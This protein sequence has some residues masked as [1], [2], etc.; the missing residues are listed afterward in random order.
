M[1][2]QPTE[3][4]VVSVFGRTCVAFARNFIRLS[5]VTGT[6][7]LPSFSFFPG[8]Q[9]PFLDLHLPVLAI[10]QLL[11]STMLLGQAIVVQYVFD[12]LAGEPVSLVA[13]TATCLRRFF[14]IAGLSLGVGVL[15]AAFAGLGGLLAQ[16][17]LS[18]T[19]LISIIFIL[20]G[21]GLFV[22]WFLATPACVVEHLG[23]LQSLGQSR[24]L[25]QRHRL[26]IF[27]LILLALIIGLILFALAVVA[28]GMINGIAPIIAPRILAHE[29]FVILVGIE[30]WLAA[31]STFLGV[32]LANTYHDL[33]L[34]KEGVS[35]DQLV[36]VFE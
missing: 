23:P 20:A 31:F 29:T 5:P 21:L 2:E 8:P 25:T 10:V 14:P 15:T 33:R 24:R 28:I 9:S 22:M 36:T 17:P 18:A 6:A 13:S 11:V 4:R 27:L 32:L 30:V 34:A 19:A 1:A 7:A 16:S 12:G 35:T 3:F 26:K